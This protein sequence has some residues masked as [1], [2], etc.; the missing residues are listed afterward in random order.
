MVAAAAVLAGCG[1][2]AEP[3]ATGSSDVP[4]SDSPAPSDGADSPAVIDQSGNLPE[5]WPSAIRLPAGG[6]VTNAFSLDQPGAKSWTVTATYDGSVT[7]VTK[8]FR[9]SLADAGFNQETSLTQGEQ[10]LLAFSGERYD[11]AV[12][13]GPEAG[14][15]VVAVTVSES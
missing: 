1:Q 12:T 3:A 15:T 8:S 14:G 9:T 4:A 2:S 10:S 5:S 11:V 13:I 7:S 6:T